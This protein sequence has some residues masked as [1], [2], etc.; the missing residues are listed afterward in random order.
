LAA[1]YRFRH[2]INGVFA[3]DIWPSVLMMEPA[4]GLAASD[5]PKAREGV[6]RRVFWFK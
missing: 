3:A 6:V 1:I 5:L 2:H 4:P